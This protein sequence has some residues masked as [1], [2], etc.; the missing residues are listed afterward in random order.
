MVVVVLPWL[1]DGT[2][3]DRMGRDVG[4]ECGHRLGTHLV[5]AKRKIIRVFGVRWCRTD[6]K[7]LSSKVCPRMLKFR[8]LICKSLP[9][10]PPPEP[11]VPEPHLFSLAEGGAP[12]PFR[13]SQAVKLS[14]RARTW[15]DIWTPDFPLGPLPMSA[16]RTAHSLP[17]CAAVTVVP[18]I[19]LASNQKI[20]APLEAYPRPDAI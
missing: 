3:R 13:A 6:L 15:I 16:N 14:R 10:A 5:Y 7:V 17:S 1:L 9:A 20:T 4:V 18:L 8:D 2:G 11:P 19:R 12:T